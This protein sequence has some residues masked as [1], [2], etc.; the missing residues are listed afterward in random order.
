MPHLHLA[1][2]LKMVPLRTVN[3]ARCSKTLEYYFARAFARQYASGIRCIQAWRVYARNG[4]PRIVRYNFDIVVNTVVI[5]YLVDIGPTVVS[6]WRIFNERMP[7]KADSRRCSHSPNIRTP[8]EC[9]YTTT[10]FKDGSM[11]SLDKHVSMQNR[12]CIS[13][14]EVTRAIVTPL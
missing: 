4:S 14:N 2:F 12:Y 7:C 6:V 1:D 11:R 5:H 3:N 9:I 10:N 13:S 8:P